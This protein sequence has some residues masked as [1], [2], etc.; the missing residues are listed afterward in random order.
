MEQ[1]LPEECSIINEDYIGRHAAAIRNLAKWINFQIANQTNMAI[2]YT[3]IFRGSNQ[4]SVHPGF[5]TSPGSIVFTK[6]NELS[7]A[8]LQFILW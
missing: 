8:L 4:H 7:I 5:L 6:P 1:I 2:K 3:L